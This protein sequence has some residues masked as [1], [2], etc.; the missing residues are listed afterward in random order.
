VTNKDDEILEE[1]RRYRKAHAASFGYDVDR[2]GRDHQEH[3]RRSGVKVVSRSPRKPLP[4]RRP[5]SV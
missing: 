4:E 1:I 5:S 3:E 2:I